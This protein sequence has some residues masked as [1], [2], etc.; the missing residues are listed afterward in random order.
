MTNGLTH[1]YT[2][3]DIGFDVPA[4]T[5]LDMLKKLRNLNVT[6][7]RRF[8]ETISLHAPEKREDA[9]LHPYEEN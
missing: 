9:S 3:A 1:L 5:E 6:L 7:E 4:F 2:K 8:D